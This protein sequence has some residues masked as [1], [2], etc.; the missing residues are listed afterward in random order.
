MNCPLFLA[1][2]LLPGAAAAHPGHLGQLAGHSH[3]VAG[4]AI[5][6]AIGIIA[7]GWA[8]GGKKA[9]SLDNPDGDTGEREA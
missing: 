2:V 1:L 5:G 8:K 3:W 9:T 4:A 7:L 6:A